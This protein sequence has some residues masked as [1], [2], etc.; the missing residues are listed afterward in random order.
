MEY[1]SSTTA[2]MPSAQQGAYDGGGQTAQYALLGGWD[3]NLKSVKDAENAV[4]QYSR[5]YNTQQIRSYLEQR[6]DTAKKQEVN[7]LQD[8][9]QVLY[10]QALV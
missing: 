8:I 4:R 5:K 1:G 9:R 7:L 6:L 10:E 2:A 3:G